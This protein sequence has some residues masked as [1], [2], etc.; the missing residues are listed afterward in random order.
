MSVGLRPRN[1][2]G[3]VRFEGHHFRRLFYVCRCT[4]MNR[5]ANG[6]RLFVGFG[7][8]TLLV[9]S[10]RPSLQPSSFKHRFNPSSRKVVFLGQL[11]RTH[12][13]FPLPLQL[14]GP[15]RPAPLPSIV[16]SCQVVFSSYHACLRHHLL[17]TQF[18]LYRQQAQSDNLYFRK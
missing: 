1:D 9:N 12:R 6:G 17:P 7:D 8:R 4:R 5:Y 11:E 3:I 13:R 18:L 15:L 2:L 10:A 16:L 14:N